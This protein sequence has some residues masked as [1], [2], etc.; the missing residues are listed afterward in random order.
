MAANAATPDAAL[1]KLSIEE[2]GKNNGASSN[3]SAGAACSPEFKEQ[4][5]AF[6]KFGDTKSDG[7]LITL[8][9][10]DKWMKQAKVIDRKITTTDTAIHFKKL[11]SLKVTF[12]D[13]NKF[14]EDLATT[15]K[16]DLAE[17]KQKMATCGAPGVAQ[18]TNVSIC[19]R[20]F[21]RPI[22]FELDLMRC[23]VWFCCRGE[24]QQLL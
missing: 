8:S 6:S 1:A 13:F 22:I 21:S 4:F 11:K 9:Q 5:K 23:N 15:R 20:W 12:S 14:L 18:I 3:G 19:F 2:N 24:R 10:S 7:K 16:V 17:I